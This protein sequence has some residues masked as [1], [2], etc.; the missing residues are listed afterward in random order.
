M[1]TVLL[2]FSGPQL[3]N[4]N[5]EILILCPL[6]KVAVRVRDSVCGAII[7]SYGALQRLERITPS[8]DTCKG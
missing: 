3:S 7:S 8:E 4:C 2:N 6:Y 5:M 1:L